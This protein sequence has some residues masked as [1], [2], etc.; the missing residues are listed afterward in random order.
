MQPVSG[1]W[2]SHTIRGDGDYEAQKR[3]ALAQSKHNE[4]IQGVNSVYSAGA[5]QPIKDSRSKYGN[6]NIMP[7][8]VIEGANSNFA[9]RDLPGNVPLADAPNQTGAVD[10]QASATRTPQQDPQ[11]FETSALEQRLAI[12]NKGGMSNLNNISALYGRG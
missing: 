6:V 2:E 10:M 11:Q 1:G 12:M 4:Y 9:Q 8:E 3:A 5:G 7:N